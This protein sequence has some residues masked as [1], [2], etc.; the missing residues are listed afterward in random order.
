MRQPQLTC[1]LSMMWFSL[2]VQPWGRSQAYLGADRSRNIWK[3]AWGSRSKGGEG[4][5]R[6]GGEG[7]RLGCEI[8]SPIIWE[9][10]IGQNPLIG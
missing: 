4:S 3:V 5:T 1:T 6:A 8:N 10:G 2:L 9:A 7:P